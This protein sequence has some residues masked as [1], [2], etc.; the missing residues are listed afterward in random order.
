MIIDTHTHTNFSTDS[1]MSITEAMSTA[2]MLGIGLTFTEHLD[3]AYPEP[4]AYVVD[5]AEY[6][7]QYAQ[8]R[9]DK[10]LLGIEIGMRLDY[11]AESAKIIS[12][13][14]LDFVIGSIHVIDNL[15][16]YQAEF[17]KGR[18]KKTVYEHYFKAMLECITNFDFIDSLGHIDYIARYARFLDP[19]FYYS[20]FYEHIDQVLSVLAGQQKAIE[21]NT[22]RFTSKP[23]VQALLPIYKRF[24]ELGG[25][26][27]TIGSDAHI[28]EDIGRAFN[29]AQEIA[30]L[31]NLKIVHYKQ[32]K[33]YYYVS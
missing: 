32:R 19:E 20:E 24:G 11:L 31:S 17:Y 33:P 30:E 9:S 10:L 29:I 4:N 2:D 26:M 28:P 22:R 16:I 27:V 5:I 15:D 13:H 18:S 23:A 8:Y 25:S 6:L 14:D 7:Q 3:L 21:I 12:E 1:K